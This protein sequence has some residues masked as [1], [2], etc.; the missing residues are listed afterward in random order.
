MPRPLPLNAEACWLKDVGIAALEIYFPSQFVDQA[1]LEKYGGV[2]A[3]K[4]IIGM[5]QAKM[6]FCTDREDINSL[7]LTVVQNLMERQHFV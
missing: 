6:G 5:G 7:C 2:D 1:E 4:Y 3:G